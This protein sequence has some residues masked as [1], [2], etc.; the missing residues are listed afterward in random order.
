M[1]PSRVLVYG[2]LINSLSLLQ[3]SMV[4]TTGDDTESEHIHIARHFNKLRVSCTVV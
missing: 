1:I 2:Q 3:D 4:T